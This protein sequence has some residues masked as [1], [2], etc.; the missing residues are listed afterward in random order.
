MFL[1]GIVLSIAASVAWPQTVT[2]SAAPAYPTRPIRLIVPIAPGGG[3]DI[4]ARAVGQRLS[5]IFGQ[6]IVV[7]NRPGAGG[8]V[9]IDIV[10]KAAPDGYTLVMTGSA[11]TIIPSLFSKVPY[12]AVKDFAPVTQA[13]S[14]PFMMGVHPSVPAKSVTDF[15]ALAKSRPGQLNYA[16]GGNGSGPHLAG[17]LLKTLTGIDMVHVPYRGGGPALLAL[18]S[19]EVAMLFSSLSSTLPQVKAGKV[20]ALAVSGAKRSPAAPELPTV[21]ESG[22]PEFEVT[23][24]FGV[25]AP[26]KTPKAIVARLQAEIVNG[27]NTPEFRTRLANDGTDIVGSTP[28]A[29]T[30]YLKTEIAKWA[31]LIK[32]LGLRME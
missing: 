30:D 9:G 26:A 5:E 31:K 27:L 6:S 21:A 8:M 22:V 24:W 15:I 17:E 29:F 25:L 7:D 16:S 1:T 32:G 19:G 3:T 18:I 11:H 2:E 20:R 13:V 14:Q 28:E 12:D 23:N 10:A 4:F